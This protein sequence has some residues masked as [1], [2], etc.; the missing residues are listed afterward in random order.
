M[1]D[2]SNDFSRWEFECSC[3]CGFDAVDVT[4]LGI[5][6]DVRDHFGQIVD[7]SGGNRCWSHHRAV[8]E[9]LGKRPTKKSG[10]LVAMAYDI[11][12]RNVCPTMV[13]AYLD[14]KY[15]DKINL[16]L[17]EKFVHVGIRSPLGRRW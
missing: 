2:L 9:R 6:Q 16:G 17:Y 1:G 15:G 5:I 8:Y 11:K 3:G 12:V 4:L 13:F 7:I 10:H 14:K